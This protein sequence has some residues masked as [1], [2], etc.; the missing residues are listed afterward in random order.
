[1]PEP[2]MYITCAVEGSKP[3]TN[4]LTPSQTQKVDRHQVYP[5]QTPSLPPKGNDSLRMRAKKKDRNRASTT[6]R[7][8][9]A[10]MSEVL[11]R[12]VR[13]IP[14]AIHVMSDLSTKQSRNCAR[15]QPLT[16]IQRK[17]DELEDIKV[18]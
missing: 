8:V 14:V 7:V 10:K 13:K 12:S 17:S 5:S 16:N 6:T 4:V 1:M 11:K 18:N 9:R 3:E 2:R 15:S